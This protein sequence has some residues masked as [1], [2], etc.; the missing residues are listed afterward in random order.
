M[1]TAVVPMGAQSTATSTQIRQTAYLK[2]SNAEKDA[3][4]GCG[5]V[6]DGTAGYGAA[7][8]GDG[9]TIAIAS[10]HES[11]AATG[12]N[13]NQTD[14]SVYDAGAV[15]VFVR[16]GAG[17]VQQAYVKP[18]NTHDGDEFGHAVALSADGNTLAVSAVW[19]SSKATGV[20]GD[21]NDHSVPQ[22]GAVYEFTRAD[23]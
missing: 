8:S 5:G 6:L 17:W 15:Y 22:S 9:N 20:N 4:F 2:A 11:S 3:Q 7:V 12:I 16:N 23:G 21:Q 18:S 13:G 10:P 1:T 14:N 19:E